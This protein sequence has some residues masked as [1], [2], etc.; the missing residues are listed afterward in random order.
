MQKFINYLTEK[1]LSK[2]SLK[3]YKS[4]LNHFSSWLILRIRSFGSYVEK[5]EQAVPFLSRETAVEYREY[6][7]NNKIPTKTINRR[8]STLRH[9]SAFLLSEGFIDYN[10]MDGIENKKL[11]S[12]T[13]EVR[14]SPIVDEFKAFLAKEAISESTQKNYISDVRQFIKWLEKNPTYAQST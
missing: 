3:N 14:L 12:I 13:K 5:L 10:F 11:Q 8:L 4:D 7:T 9:L 1:K 2:H 6:L